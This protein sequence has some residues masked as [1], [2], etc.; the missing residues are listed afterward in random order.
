MLRDFRRW[1]ECCSCSFKGRSLSSLGQTF[2]IDSLNRDFQCEKASSLGSELSIREA[3]PFWVHP[4]SSRLYKSTIAF[5][6]LLVSKIWLLFY[7]SLALVRNYLIYLFPLLRENHRDSITIDR[8]SK[9]ASH[10]FF[11]A[12]LLNEKLLWLVERATTFR[13]FVIYK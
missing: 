9:L 1:N 11:S 8:R 6:F 4:C 12:F 2:G 10:I 13:N 3:N 7:S 5:S